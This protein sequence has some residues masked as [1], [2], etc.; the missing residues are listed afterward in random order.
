MLVLLYSRQ[1]RVHGSFYQHRSAIS[2]L[3]RVHDTSTITGEAVV[4]FGLSEPPRFQ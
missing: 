2:S 4:L 3:E 1:L